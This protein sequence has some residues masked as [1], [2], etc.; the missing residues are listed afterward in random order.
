M[1]VGGVDELEVS[2]SLQIANDSL[3]RF[4]VLG[5]GARVFGARGEAVDG[6]CNVGAR[7]KYEDEHAE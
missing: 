5:G 3:E 7:A 1:G 2:G 6:I 4:I